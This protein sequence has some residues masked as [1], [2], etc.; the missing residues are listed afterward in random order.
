MDRSYIE[1]SQIVESFINRDTKTAISQAV[2]A[3]SNL[4]TIDD[5]ERRMK[6]AF[7]NVLRE[8]MSE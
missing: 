3:E 4:S 5:R 2:E 7:I 6:L 8:E 1:Y